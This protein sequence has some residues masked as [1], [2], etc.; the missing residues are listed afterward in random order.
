MVGQVGDWHPAPTPTGNWLTLTL[1]NSRPLLRARKGSQGSVLS[2]RRGQWPQLV[3]RVDTRDVLE[4]TTRTSWTAPRAHRLSVAW[5]SASIWSAPDQSS[6]LRFG[7]LVGPDGSR[8]SPSD[9]LDDQTDDQARQAAPF[10]V[11]S[12][13]DVEAGARS[14]GAA[15]E[16]L[17]LRCAGPAGWQARF[18]G[19]QPV[20]A[21]GRPLWRWARAR[22]SSLRRPTRSVSI[23]RE[24]ASAPSL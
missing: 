16:S 19:D 5:C 12:T 7:C 2:H 20:G 15:R 11:G 3:A 22:L 10:H 24:G 23:Q 8:R 13:Q 14:P 21:P 17:T 1:P 4:C 6:L 9:R 18:A